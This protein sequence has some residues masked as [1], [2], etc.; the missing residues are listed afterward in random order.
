MG[1]SIIALK[2]YGHCWNK[3]I[4]ANLKQNGKF[5]V[6]ALHPMHPSRIPLKTSGYKRKHCCANVTI[7]VKPLLK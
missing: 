3:S 1:Q 7:A 5:T 4:E 2:H 6:L